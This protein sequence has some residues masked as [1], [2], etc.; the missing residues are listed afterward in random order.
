MGE[1]PQATPGDRDGGEAQRRVPKDTGFRLNSSTS[2]Q[3]QAN[4]GSP[5]MLKH[6]AAVLCL[7]MFIA[8][9][10]A[11]SPSET[12]DLLVEAVREGD[13]VEIVRH[14]DIGRVASSAVEPLFQAAAMMDVADPDRFRRQTGGMG[15]EMLEQ[16]KPM[17]APMME[18][19]FWQMMLHPEAFEEG[20]IG[21]VLGGQPLPFAQLG[22]AYQGVTSE[23]RD[24]DDAIVSMELSH[25]SSGR[26][27]VLDMRLEETEDGWRVVSFDNLQ[28]T[29][30]NILN[31]AN[32]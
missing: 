11:P 13:S 8:C 18:Q 22:D 29:I 16:F 4:T 7:T 6:S 30:T 21:Q 17:I 26:S 19:L 24:G 2:Y 28:E 3:T 5:F 9:R 1:V 14:I 25:E 20:P 10:S 23:R 27:V 32:R 15:I 12:V 31:E